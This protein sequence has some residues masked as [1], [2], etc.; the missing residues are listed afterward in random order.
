MHDINKRQKKLL[1]LLLENQNFMPVKY[2]AELLA[3][4]ARTLYKDLNQLERLLF[5]DRA[6][7][8]RMPRKGVFLKSDFTLYEILGSNVSNNEMTS[9]S[10]FFR[11][12]TIA[13]QLLVEN[14]L[15]TYQELSENFLVSKT[16][17]SNDIEQIQQV[18]K[19][20]KIDIYS[21]HNG[22][23]IIGK[24]SD[25]Q[26]AIKDYA[27]FI[28]S[29]VENSSDFRM[30]FPQEVE[31]FLMGKQVTQQVLSVVQNDH[32][33]T[34]NQLSDNYFQS[35]ILSISILVVRVQQNFHI[36]DKHYLLS[37]N[38]ASLTT[39]FLTKD[40][41]ERLQSLQNVILCQ[42]DFDYLNK[43]LIAHGLE[44]NLEDLSVK[45][46]YENIT[47]EIIA[48]MSQSLK[49]DLTNDKKLFT[50]I[51]Y[52]LLSMIYRLRMNMPIKNPL[53][54]EIKNNYSI[55]YSTTWFVLSK[56]EAK[57]SIEFNEDEIAF[58]AIHF[59]G[60]VDRSS[61][62]HRILIVC[63]T[64]IG[65]SELIANRLKKVL[66]PHDTLEVVSI[67]TLYQSDLNKVDMIISSV[68]LEK[69]AIPVV[70][71]SPLMNRE[72]LKKVLSTYLDLFYDETDENLNLHFDYLST[73]LDPRLVF[74]DEKF[75]T[76]KD[77]IKKI[78]NELSKINAVKPGFL[79]AVCKREKIGVT[80]LPTGVA[81]PH[82]PAD[83][84][85]KSKLVVITLDKPIRWHSRLVRVILMICIAEKD[86]SK[87]KGILSDIYKIVESKKNVEGLFFSKTK[88]EVINKLGGSKY[89]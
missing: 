43:Q 83:V 84:V 7:L 33:S 41:A 73:I 75:T 69:V 76:K 21:N 66:F 6:V 16:S 67:R 74:L 22:T 48:E 18:T 4:S 26:K 36:E 8:K 30:H 62:S 20:N 5:K 81:I 78:T 64:G 86:F 50:N 54:E 15:V 72:D 56:F 14:K 3:V 13:R 29:K 10:P 39:Y 65:T 71:V 31:Y 37:E 46:E 9:Q 89:D 47:K 11:Q 25:I 88:S 17:I 60:A 24:E 27:Y 63:P 68:N 57:L 32:S 77:C 58:L 61:E 79:E 12:I 35:L 38:I 59:Q 49:I 45:S 40:L 2:Y 87:V 85:V 52:H 70:H 19:N 28:V 44:P 51:L 53:L 42:N 82:P 1:E 80:D 34:I 23:K 55:L